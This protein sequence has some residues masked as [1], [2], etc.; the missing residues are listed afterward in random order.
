MLPYKFVKQMPGLPVWLQSYEY[1]TP[2][3]SR[4]GIDAQVVAYLLSAYA[5]CNVADSAP[6][7]PRP[8]V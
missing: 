5:A 1:L 6:L 4:A 8:Q 3:L 7:H 2:A